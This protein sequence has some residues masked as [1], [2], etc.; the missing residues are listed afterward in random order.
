[1]IRVIIINY[2][3]YRNRRLTLSCF[4]NSHRS[5]SEEVNVLIF[6]LVYSNENKLMLAAFVSLNILFKLI[7]GGYAVA[8]FI[9]YCADISRIAVL[10]NKSLSIKNVLE[11]TGSNFHE[12]FEQ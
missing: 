4:C 6:Y 3:H 1:V 2:H 10:D 12:Y 5:D 11:I 7:S 8:I 9:R